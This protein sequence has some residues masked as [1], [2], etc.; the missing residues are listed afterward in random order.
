M[1]EKFK[2]TIIILSAGNGERMQSSIPKV[3]HE[4]SMQPIIEY[5]VSLAGAF[6]SDS[7]LI[8]IVVNKELQSHKVFKDI[9]SKYKLKN[10]LQRQKL[11]TG[12]AVKVACDNIDSINDLVLILYGD[13]PFFTKQTIINMYNN[14]N[15]GADL[16]ILGFNAKNSDGYGRIISHENNRIIE[17]IEDVDADDQQK[18]IKLCNS[19]IILVKKHV[20]K[21][22]LD[23]NEGI[24]YNSKHEF[25]LTD[26]VKYAVLRKMVCTYILTDEAEV[27][28]INN[29]AQL[30]NAEYYNQ[31]L[32]V[33]KLL[34][35]GVTV[36]NPE[37]SYFANNINIQKDVIIYPNVFIGKDT[38]IS[39]NSIINSFS[40]MEG[41]IIEEKSIIGPFARIRPK[42]K[43]GNNVKIGNF[44][45]VKNSTLM[46]NVKAGHL[47]YIGD[48]TISKDVNIGA[49]TVFCNY[50]GK[51]KHHSFVG[52]KVFIGSNT[53][54]VSPVKIDSKSMVAAGS[55]ITKNVKKND[56]AL[57]RSKQV[58]FKN[59]SKIS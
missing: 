39:K 57:A 13:T 52:E 8:N 56:L 15:S 43:I 37:S 51:N 11:G 2:P 44:V 33:K 42:T 48:A 27:M 32:I 38:V 45:E 21:G 25:Y 46:N 34:N 18:Q 29:R 7:N 12:D 28:G 26:I 19:G 1:Q 3:L 30:V 23:E 6:N 16:C 20:I 59:K 17:I 31:R 35:N 22:F 58:N 36:I 47:S 55:V 53:S 5:V 54:I 24:N 14:I 10:I 40:H 50:D 4:I 49:G 41:A 9:A